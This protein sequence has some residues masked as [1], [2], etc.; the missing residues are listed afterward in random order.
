LAVM[1]GSVR[2]GGVGLAVVRC[3]GVRLALMRGGSMG[4]SGIA[5][6]VGCPFAVRVY[7]RCTAGVSVIADE[8]AGISSA[9]GGD[10][11][12]AAPTV[13]ISP[14]GPWT[15]AQEDAVVEV[16]RPIITHRG[17][18]IRCIAVV[19]VRTDRWWTPYADGNLRIRFWRQGQGRKQS[20]GKQ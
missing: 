7:D 4:A 17:A 18:G 8:A 3:G 20:C 11:A 5:T 16:A 2:G 15:H 19:A 14:A 12:M 6:P 9:A 1:R 13:V 10:K